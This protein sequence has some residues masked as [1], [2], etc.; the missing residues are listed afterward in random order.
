MVQ[1]LYLLGANI[2]GLLILVAISAH[3]T[4]RTVGRPATSGVCREFHAVFRCFNSKLLPRERRTLIKKN[5]RTTRAV[6]VAVALIAGLYLAVQLREGWFPHDAGSLGQSAERVLQGDMPHADFSEL[7]TGGLTFVHAG[8][9]RVLGVDLLSLRVLLL[10]SFTLWIYCLFRLALHHVP[11]WLS[12]LVVALAVTW[13]VP[14]YPAPMPSW[15]NLF[16]ATGALLALTRF[17]ETSGKKYLWLAGLA[18]GIS[19]TTKIAG[20]YL[21]VGVAFYLLFHVGTVPRRDH[22]Q[23]DSRH[24]AI[25]VSAVAAAVVVGL[26]TLIARSGGTAQVFRFIV[27]VAALTAVMF[28]EEW[29]RGHGPV[30]GQ[31]VELLKLAVPLLGGIAIPLALLLLPYVATGSVGTLIEGTLIRPASRFEY[32]SRPP[33]PLVSVVS[34]PVVAA[35]VGLELTLDPARRWMNLVLSAAF[36]ILVI[37]AAAHYWSVYYF[38]WLSAYHAAPFAVVIGCLW[39]IRSDASVNVRRGMFAIL[40]VTAFAGFVEFPYAGELY[41]L[42]VAPIVFLAVASLVHAAVGRRLSRSAIALPALMYVAFAALLMNSQ[43]PDTIGLKYVKGRETAELALPRAS[44]RVSRADSAMYGELVRI[45]ERTTSGPLVYA[46]PDSPEV[47]YLLGGRNR[48]RVL[49]E[50]LES[51]SDHSANRFPL[52]DGHAGFVVVNHEPAFS[53]PLPPHVLGRIRQSFEQDA[54]SGRFEIR[55]R[56]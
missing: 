50:F 45:A 13:S 14:N 54:R 51:D 1:D 48:T 12:V 7:Y 22:V 31:V 3:S 21:A 55:W 24:F 16:F 28:T 33:L 43:L 56:R 40:C 25:L 41:F 39:L 34:V 10:F 47:Y 23:A 30:G 17:A 37:F 53:D 8:A 5:V 26:G 29:K 9:F 44:I 32:A 11:F 46:G 4:A 6:G 36:W 19:I 35:I 20:V 42:Y 38:V 18:I 27:P 52:V 15:Y 2:G 49:F